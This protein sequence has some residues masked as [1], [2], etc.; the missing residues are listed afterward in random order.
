MDAQRLVLLLIFGF[1]VLML[2]EGWEREHRPKPAA[3]APAAQQQGIP[4]PAPLAPSTPAQAA[5]RAAPQAAPAVSAA[6]AEARGETLRVTTDVVIA[7]IDT[8]GGT[9]KHL[10]LLRHKDSEDEKKNLML[11]GPDRHYEAQSG[12]AGEGGPNHRTLWRGPTAS[13]SVSPP[14][15]ATVWKCRRSIPSSATAT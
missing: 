2:W 1:S 12:I 7:E 15:G 10:E 3:Q 5:A 6:E 4:V 11:L 14:K 13:K 8:L 9:L